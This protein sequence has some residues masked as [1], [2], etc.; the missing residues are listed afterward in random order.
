MKVRAIGGP[1][2]EG[3][4]T[5]AK[6]GDGLDQGLSSP[7]R[8][9]ECPFYPDSLTAAGSQGP[10]QGDILCPLLSMVCHVPFS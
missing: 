8:L 1:S 4:K 7:H 10:H 3:G 2:P 5:E 9:L 6:E